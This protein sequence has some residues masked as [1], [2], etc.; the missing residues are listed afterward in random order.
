MATE[1]V[2][3]VGVTVDDVIKSSIKLPT[4]STKNPSVAPQNKQQLLTQL[5]FAVAS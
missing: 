1:D 3:C 5:K 2:A 4:L